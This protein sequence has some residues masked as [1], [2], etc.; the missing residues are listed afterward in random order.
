MSDDNRVTVHILDKE[1]QVACKPDE[2][3]E[4]MRAASELDD[5]MRAAR[6]GGNIVGLERIAIMVAL[7]LCHELQTKS[8]TQQLPDPE[9]DAALERISGKLDSALSE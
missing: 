1:Y 6:K 3:H 9:T 8:G 5:R 2:R 7:N 4:L